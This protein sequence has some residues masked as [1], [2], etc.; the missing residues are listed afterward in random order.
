MIALHWRKIE[1]KRKVIIFQLMYFMYLMSSVNL[2]FYDK[3]C[4]K[5]KD[6]LYPLSVAINLSLSNLIL[7]L[8]EQN[9]NV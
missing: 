4:N 2:S 1:R 5:K 3:F 9:C 7:F 8:L 6:F